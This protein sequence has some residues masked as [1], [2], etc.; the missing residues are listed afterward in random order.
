MATWPDAN[1]F[2]RFLAGAGL[3]SDPPTAV[4]EYIDLE[5]ALTAAVERWNE[6]THYWPFLST[7]NVNESRYLSPRGGNIL[8]LK[9]GLLTF[10]SLS[11][12][13][14]YDSVTGSLGGGNQRV[15]IQDFRLMPEDAPPKGKPWTY[16]V[17]GWTFWGDASSIIV[18]GEWGFC[19]TTNLPESARQAVMALAA[20]AIMPQLQMYGSRGGLVMLQQGDTTKK[21]GSS[22]DMSAG[23]KSIVDMA[24]SQGFVR[25]RIA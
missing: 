18:T 12:D 24:L 20:Q 4:Q 11:T 25:M 7:G 15:N 21:W 16:M 17:T 9:S 22:S 14:S 1:E 2:I 5:A 23:F 8:D 6:L 13:L 3:L 10:T 19:R